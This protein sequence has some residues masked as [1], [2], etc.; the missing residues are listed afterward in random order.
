MLA[1]R[2]VSWPAALV[3]IGFTIAGQALAWLVPHS[4][5]GR[6]S[7]AALGVMVPISL[8]LCGS[9]LFWTSV[10]SNQSM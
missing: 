5:I 7:D 6:V 1:A 10:I 9:E 8:F 4:G 2:A 3:F